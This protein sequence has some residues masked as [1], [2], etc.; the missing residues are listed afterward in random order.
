MTAPPPV[1]AKPFACTATAPVITPDANSPALSTATFTVTCNGPLGEL[2]VTGTD[3]TANSPAGGYTKPQS[4][5]GV[6]S[7][8]GVVFTTSSP[9]RG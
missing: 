9:A 4:W 6:A 2:N 1:A 3:Y 5:K 7:G 8:G